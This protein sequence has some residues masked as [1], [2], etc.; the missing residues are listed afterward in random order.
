MDLWTKRKPWGASPEAFLID[1][2]CR[3][4][5]ASCFNR[6]KQH[7]FEIF[8][9]FFGRTS[10]KQKSS[11]LFFRAGDEHQKSL[12]FLRKGLIFKKLHFLLRRFVAKK[13]QK[14]V[15]NSVLN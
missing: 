1:L 2:G 4:C 7:S 13:C 15:K 5:F 14:T 11:L 8:R 3:R 12:F 9:T 10:S 6:E